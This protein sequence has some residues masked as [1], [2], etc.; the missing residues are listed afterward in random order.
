MLDQD[1]GNWLDEGG[2]MW[3]VGCDLPVQ[4]NK[5]SIEDNSMF[6]QPEQTYLR[7]VNSVA[8]FRI[9]PE[10]ATNPVAVQ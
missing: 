9:D 8:N 2:D 1:E 10:R 3:A 5:E 4:K 6:T 7:N